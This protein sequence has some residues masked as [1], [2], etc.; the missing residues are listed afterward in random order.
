MPAKSRQQFKFFKAMEEKPEKA[1]T[2]GI[3]PTTV[4]DF[5]QGMT[6]DRWK[7][8]RDKVTKK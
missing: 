2:L 6:K 4:N 1:K 5:T 3:S 8:L 7:K